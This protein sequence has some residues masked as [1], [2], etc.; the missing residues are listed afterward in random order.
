MSIRNYVLANTVCLTETKIENIALWW[1]HKGHTKTADVLRCINSK[2]GVKTDEI[3]SFANCSNVPCLVD[4]INKRLKPH[5]YKIERLD[6]QG[7]AVNAD[8]HSWYLINIPFANPANDD[9]FETSDSD[10]VNH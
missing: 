1:G 7:K 2:P 4:S 6:P 5:G 3:R 8:F 9:P 10:V